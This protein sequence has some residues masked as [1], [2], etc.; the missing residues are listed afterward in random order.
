MFQ[1]ELATSWPWVKAKMSITSA[2]HETF[3]RT[4]WNIQPLLNI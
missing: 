4:D 2:D 3:V 1:N